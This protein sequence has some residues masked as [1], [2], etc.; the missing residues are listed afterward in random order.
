[1]TITATTIAADVVDA[2]VAA[3]RPDYTSTESWDD[4]SLTAVA[5]L[6]AERALAETGYVTLDG[7]RAYRA[8]HIPDARWNGFL[9]PCFTREIAALI[10]ADV[11]TAYRRASESH[12]DGGTCL[13]WDGETIV[14]TADGWD[15]S[16]P[17]YRYQPMPHP[18]DPDGPAVYALGSGWT[19]QHAHVTA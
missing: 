8:A 1:M 10:I 11:R 3:Q 17:P 5:E 13:R 14:E 15:P 4:D 18:T 19:W 2:Y 12:G 7:E 16:D 6:A 9:T